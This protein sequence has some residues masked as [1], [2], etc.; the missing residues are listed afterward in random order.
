M[1]RTMTDSELRLAVYELIFQTGHVPLVNE[2]ATARRIDEAA[3]RQGLRRLAAV[4]AFVVDD[5]DEI[6]MAHP[7]SALETPYTV[8]GD[9][10]RFRANCAWDALAIPAML[11]INARV[12]A[13]CHCACA[14]PIALAFDQGVLHPVD[15]VVH[16]A[17][18]PRRFY[19]NITF[20]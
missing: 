12:A 10:L 1:R 19:D 5:K 13:R 16:F 14:D 20:T 7:F 11:K 3:V 4:H 2:I 18:P 9:T 17:V 8:A 6:V 15:A